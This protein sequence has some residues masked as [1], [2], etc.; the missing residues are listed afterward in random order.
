[1]ATNSCFFG[2]GRGM[3]TLTKYGASGTNHIDLLRNVYG[4]ASYYYLTDSRPA[5]RVALSQE[6]LRAPRQ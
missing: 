2:V 3:V 4:L 6:S 1:M 5:E